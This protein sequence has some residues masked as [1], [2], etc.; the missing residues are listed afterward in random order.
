MSRSILPLASSY[1]NGLLNSRTGISDDYHIPRHKVNCLLAQQLIKFSR[2]I[3][4]KITEL[5]AVLA[6]ESSALQLA[7]YHILHYQIPNAQEQ[8]SLEKALEKEFYAKLPEELLSL[9]ITAPNPDLFD[10]RDF[11]RAVSHPLRSYLLSWKLIFDHWTNSSDK[12]KA[13]YAAG[14]KEGSY[15]QSLLNFIFQICISNRTKPLDASAIDKS[16][17]EPGASN[18]LE[19]ETHELLVHLYYLSLKY[20][21]SLCRSWWR[22]T[23]SRQT[24]IAVET[25]TEKYVSPNPRSYSD[26]VF[27]NHYLTDLPPNNNIRAPS[28]QRLGTISIQHRAAHGN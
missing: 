9:I 3:G 10:E 16:S 6:C 4:N 7:A 25:W 5:Y 11:A 1:Y 28:H 12:T 22:D 20:L 24:A 13:D 19:D 8:I 26:A 17:F 27:T 23:T 14:L 21:P 15:L 2:E 18:T